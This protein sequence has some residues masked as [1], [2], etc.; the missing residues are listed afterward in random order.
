M[1]NIIL[2]FILCL[3]SCISAFSQEAEQ[4]DKFGILQCDDYLGRIGDMFNRSKNY[5]NSKVYVFVYEGK[6]QIYN[7]GNDSKFLGYKEVFPQFGEAKAKIQSM[8][9]KLLQYDKNF[10]KRFVFINSGF[11]ENFVVEFWIVPDGKTPPKPSPTLK[12][13]KYRAGKAKG[14]CLDLI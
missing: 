9:K 14:F 7:R 4:F 10:Q 3:M 5:P 13:M 8:K 12:K 2:T 11:R 1:K 6:Y